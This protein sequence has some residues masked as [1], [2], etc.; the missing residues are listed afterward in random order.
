MTILVIGATG[1]VGRPTIAGLLAKGT[2][3]RALS[4]S[5]ENLAKLPEG[6]DGERLFEAALERVAGSRYTY[7]ANPLA[8]PEAKERGMDRLALVGMGC[9]TS[10]P[11]TMS[12]RVTVPMATQTAMA[13]PT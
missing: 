1:N 13:I 12:T 9:Q 8:L 10:S 11:P 4:R 2:S 3:V 7:C 6:V 5:Q